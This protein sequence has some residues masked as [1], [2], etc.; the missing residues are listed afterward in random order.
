MKS[1][2]GRCIAVLLIGL[3]LLALSG[4]SGS[5]GEHFAMSDDVNNFED[6]FEMIYYKPSD[7]TCSAAV[8][9]DKETGVMYYRINSLSQLAITPLYNSDGSIMRYDLEEN[10]ILRTS[11]NER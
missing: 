3:T 5:V 2:F 10:H 6:R 7:T 9:V 4:C 1:N 11:S 8:F